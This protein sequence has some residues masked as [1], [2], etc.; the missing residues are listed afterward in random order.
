MIGL[1]IASHGQLGAELV[2]TAKQIVGELPQ[3]A[4]CSVDPGTAPD[5]L[6]LKLRE[7]MHSV[8][9]GQGVIVFADLIGGS[10]C[11][12]SLSLCQQARIEVITGVNLPMLL[13]ANTLR[14]TTELHELALQL[15]Q[16]GQRNI[17][18]A[19]EMLRLKAVAATS[20]AEAGGTT[21]A[22]A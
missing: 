8:D 20:T 13:K 1:V 22:S 12:Q 16:Y 10:P 2:S 3:V 6:K 9:Q 15:T 14:Q 11:N 21:T 17:T 5:E 18:C 4:S 7:A 19:T